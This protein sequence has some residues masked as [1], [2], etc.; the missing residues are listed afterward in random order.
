MVD[1]E[2]IRDRLGRLDPLLG[3]L[4]AAHEGGEDAYRSDRDLQL[5]VERALQLALQICIDVGAHLVVE[6]GLTPPS[7]YRGVFTALGSAGQI[8][9]ELAERLA[10]ASGLRNILVH[11]YVDLDDSLVFAALSRLDDLREFAR[12]AEAAAERE[13]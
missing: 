11:E 4:E 9:A 2:T 7:D 10:L 5:R 12:A 8:D 13:D 6:L 1:P 3:I